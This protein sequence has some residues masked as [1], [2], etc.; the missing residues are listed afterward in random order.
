MRHPLCRRLYFDLQVLRLDYL[1]C[2]SDKPETRNIVSDIAK[3][4]GVVSLIPNRFSYGGKTLIVCDTM[5]LTHLLSDVE[6]VLGV[7]FL[8]VDAPASLLDL[9]EEKKVHLLSYV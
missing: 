9:C 1:L 3:F 7:L 5:Q 8:D 6:G 4:P 2:H